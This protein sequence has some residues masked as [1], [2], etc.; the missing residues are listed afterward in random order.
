MLGPMVSREQ[1]EMEAEPG[2]QGNAGRDQLYV[3]VNHWLE[4]L[5]A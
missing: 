1:C 5:L 3:W 4:R 2:I